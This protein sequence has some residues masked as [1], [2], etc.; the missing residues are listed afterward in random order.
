MALRPDKFK[1]AVWDEE[2]RLVGIL[3]GSALRKR[4]NFLTPLH[5]ILSSIADITGA[6][7]GLKPCGIEDQDKLTFRRRIRQCLL[8]EVDVLFA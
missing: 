1:S 3:W 8:S 6:Y 4:T 7:Y 5:K 2:G